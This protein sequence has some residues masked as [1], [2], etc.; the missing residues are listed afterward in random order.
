MVLPLRLFVTI[1]AT[2]SWTAV[3][4]ADLV[5]PYGGETAPDFA[6]VSVL[7]DRV[8]VALEIDPADF[9]FFVRPDD[10]TGLPL[11]ERTGLT[12]SVAADGQ[13]LVPVIRTV[14][15]RPRKPRITAATAIVPP[16]PRSADVVFAELEFPFDDR[17]ERITL[18]PPLDTTGMPLA[19]LGLLVDHLGVPVTDYRYLSRT[20]TLMPDWDDPWFSAFEN[21]NLTRHHKSPLMSF[22][23]M[24]PRE[25]RHEIIL[26]LRDLEGWVDL[27]LGDAASLGPAQM[28]GVEARAADFLRHRN[29]VAIDGERVVPA[30][31]RVSRVA[32][33]A[34]GLRVVEE[35]QQ[36]DRATTLLGVIL[37]Y[38]RESLAQDVEMTWELFPDSL[39]S[40]PV[41]LTDPAGGVPAQ[42]RV[43][44]PVVRWT[45][46]L[47]DW[48]EPQA[49]PVTVST[50]TIISLPILAGAF[51][52]GALAA[53][54]SAFRQRGGRRLGLLAGAAMA[55]C[56]AVVAAPV[57]TRISLPGQPE[58]TAEAAQQLMSGLLNNAG[59]AMLETRSDAFAEAL[60]QF[61][62]AERITEVG[63]EL[64]RG[65]AVTLPSGAMARTDEIVD[66]KVERIDPAENGTGSQILATWA[67]SVSGGHWGHLHR[68]QVTYRGL[69]DVS[70]Q[71]D[72]WYLDGLTILSAEIKT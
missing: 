57:S 44:N 46:Y 56:A 15:L 35:A 23:S 58:P 50:A 63:A 47:R 69:V 55:L 29:P 60:T 51:V 32:V 48:T 43:G 22:L 11:S 30:D 6:E 14:D 45:N 16:R 31:I 37:S 21:P 42:V 2:A 54:W 36:S 27:G 34:E 61:V 66:L 40:V 67:A 26:R 9:P 3:A 7:P 49:R 17:P 33:G 4:R 8:R 52:I 19:S 72:R 25:V 24:E 18:T 70:R 12:L 5:S 59:T 41:T 10:G 62:P 13:P 28:A 53:A 64:H 68:R 1:L 65:L 71:Q 38:P 20:E 39:T